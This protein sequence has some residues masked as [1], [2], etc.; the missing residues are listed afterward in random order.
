MASVIQN[1]LPSRTG[2]LLRVL[3]KHL[4][5]LRQAYGVRAFWLFGSYVRGEEKR[6]SDLDVLVEFEIAP[7]FF[8]FIELEERLSQLL[9]VKVDLVMKRALKPGIGQYILAEAVPV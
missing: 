4:P 8:R 7:S 1:Q 5:D 3:Q 6:A 2:E 9:G